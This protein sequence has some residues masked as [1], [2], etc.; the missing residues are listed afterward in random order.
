MGEVLG[1]S[2][3]ALQKGIA[4]FLGNLCPVDRKGIVKGSEGEIDF[5]DG[6]QF[7]VVEASL[8][9]PRGIVIN[10]EL[11][12]MTQ[13]ATFFVDVVLPEL[14]ALLQRLSI[15]GCI[16]GERQRNANLHR[17]RGCGRDGIALLHTRAEQQ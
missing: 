8:L 1:G 11:D 4:I 10:D 14:V 15:T 17:P 2:S 16:S 12:L 7:L 9:G 3:C 6:Y 13:K 5:I